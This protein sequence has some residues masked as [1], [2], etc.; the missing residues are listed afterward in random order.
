[1]LYMIQANLFI[2]SESA[3]KPKL[4][5]N[6]VAIEYIRIIRKKVTVGGLQRLH[7]ELLHFALM[8]MQNGI[9]YN[10]IIRFCYTS[11]LNTEI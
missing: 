6:T 5:I 2:Q 11:M 4:R 9:T 3:S 10:L 7:F 1:M 8:S